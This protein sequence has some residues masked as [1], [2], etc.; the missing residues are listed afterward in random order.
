MT[1]GGLVCMNTSTLIN[2]IDFT[3]QSYQSPAFLWKK[4]LLT[5]KENSDMW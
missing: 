2:Q 5:S 1:A 4:W 3:A